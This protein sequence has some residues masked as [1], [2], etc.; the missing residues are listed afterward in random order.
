MVAPWKR[1][2]GEFKG[3]FQQHI[4][5]VAFIV[6]RRKLPRHL[7]PSISRFDSMKCFTIAFKKTAKE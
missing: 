7:N 4:K 5:S 6:E 1:L 3:S 2:V